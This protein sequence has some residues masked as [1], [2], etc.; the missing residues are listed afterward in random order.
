MLPHHEGA[1]FW[2]NYLILAPGFER[3]DSA[4]DGDLVG[5]LVG[6]L[7]LPQAD[8]SERSAIAATRDPVVA[9]VDHSLKKEVSAG[10]FR[11]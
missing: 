5:I 8:N 2:I 3:N 1:S 4:A 7:R 6:W 11:I 10:S 9:F